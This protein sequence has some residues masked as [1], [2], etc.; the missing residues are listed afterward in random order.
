MELF[1]PYISVGFCRALL[2]RLTPYIEFAQTR[3]KAFGFLRFFLALGLLANIFERTLG[4]FC[5]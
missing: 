4:I 1:F 5:R 2:A 3:K